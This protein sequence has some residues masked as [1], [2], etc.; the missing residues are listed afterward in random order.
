MRALAGAVAAAL[1]AGCSGD[2][3]APAPVDAGA[4]VVDVPPVD[5][6][7][8]SPDVAVA[9][10]WAGSL[11]LPFH[12]TGISM[13]MGGYDR[14]DIV[15][16]VGSIT[17]GGDDRPAL[18]AQTVDWSSQG[19]QLVHYYSTDA[20]ELTVAFLYCR[21]GHTA[22]VYVESLSAPITLFNDATVN[23][24]AV[25]V[26]AHTVAA[27]LR[28]FEGPPPGFEPVRM[29][30]IAG[31]GLSLDEQGVG[32]V[33]LGGIDWDLTPFSWVDCPAASCGG[34]GWYE[35]HSLLRG[36]GGATGSVILYLMRD[37]TMQV[38]TSYGLRFD[39]PGELPN[40]LFHVSWAL[41]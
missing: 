7:M 25:T 15:D 3:A 4:V 26:G 1:A 41:L 13:P 2:A 40:T 12:Y 22:G 39:V 33:T 17:F 6:A 20:H 23:P 28:P 8:G 32:R 34:P 9:G 18:V 38:Q 11:Q 37:N 35:V 19:Y 5:A 24:C 30:T 31:A 21:G 14:A 10:T 16:N 29:A 27:R 36:Q